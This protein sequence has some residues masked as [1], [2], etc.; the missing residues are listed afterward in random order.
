MARETKDMTKLLQRV[1]RIRGQ[2]EAIERALACEQKCER[3]LNLVAAC[4]G[5]LSS[6]MVEIVEDRVRSLATFSNGDRSS[7][8]TRP[9]REL[10][11]VIRSYLK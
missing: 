10:M 4:R 6:L 1:R 5:A 11:G 2:V 3:V 7:L 8:K 9:V